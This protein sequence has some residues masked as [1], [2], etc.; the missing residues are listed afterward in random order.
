MSLRARVLAVAALIVAGWFGPA[1]LSQAAGAPAVVEIV[2]V[3]SVPGA[4]FLFDGRPYS[5]DQQGL[6]RVT[7]PVPG[8]RH[9]LTL[10][11]TT[12]RQPR[13]DLTFVR[14]WYPRDHDQDNRTTLTGITV[15]RNVRIKAA[16]RASYLVSY[17]FVDP[18]QGPVSSKRVRR[19]EFRGDN[20]TTATGDGSGK[21]RLGGIQAKV[22]D[23]TLVAKHV[24]YT[25]QSVEV[26]GS[27]VVQMNHQQFLPSHK[28]GVVVPLLLRTAHLS[29]RDFLFGTPVGRSVELTYPDEHKR[30]VA[31]DGQ[32]QATL[33]D[34][35]RGHY[36]VRVNASGYSFERPVALSRNQYVDLPV[37]T[38]LDIAVVVAGILLVVAGL[39]ALRIR[40]RHAH[41]RSN[42]ERGPA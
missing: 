42:P 22:T 38:S 23:G 40:T 8:G 17:S 29:T 20:G 5:A 34:L 30:T 33:E 18:A 6:V 11:D 15:R 14:W 39:F 25:V 12:I 3:P 4:R 10:V 32:G 31:L 1:P 2:T 28:P 24:T 27:N 9:R 19:V 7:L 16:F 36:L 35:A 13:R 37:L 21:I 41:E 26:D